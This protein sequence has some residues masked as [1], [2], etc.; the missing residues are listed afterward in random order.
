MKRV[1]NVIG[2]ILILLFAGAAIIY[3]AV[4]LSKVF[5]KNEFTEIQFNALSVFVEGKEED[6]LLRLSCD[7]MRIVFRYN[8][9]T[10]LFEGKKNVGYKPISV[11]DKDIMAVDVSGD[12]VYL[13]MGRD[14]EP[15]GAGDYVIMIDHGII[16]F[17]SSRNVCLDN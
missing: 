8:K 1:L 9:D 17:L 13:R 14:Y 6:P 11:E 15:E 7:S 16:V 2:S 12:S 4:E 10:I 5:G 3:G